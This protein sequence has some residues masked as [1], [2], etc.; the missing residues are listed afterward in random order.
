MVAPVLDLI[1]E[2]Y[3]YIVEAINLEDELDADKAVA[4]E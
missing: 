2:N 1:L 3:S 4:R